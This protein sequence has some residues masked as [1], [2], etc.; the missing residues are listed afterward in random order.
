[1]VDRTD[2]YLRPRGY[3]DNVGNLLKVGFDVINGWLTGKTDKTE[4]DAHVAEFNS[5]VADTTWTAPTLLNG[6]VNYGGSLATAG[7]T[8]DAHGFVHLKG[9]I[10]NGTTT[11]NTVLFSLPLGYRPPEHHH[12]AVYGDAGVAGTVA[13]YKTGDVVIISGSANGLGLCG[14]IFKVT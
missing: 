6:W 12:F 3:Y 8:K 11:I 5:H 10:K 4:F 7:Y 2:K 14:I 9:N 1:M 13:V